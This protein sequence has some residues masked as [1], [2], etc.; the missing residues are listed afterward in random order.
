M[1]SKIILIIVTLIEEKEKNSISA[2]SFLMNKKWL[3][4]NGKTSETY[5]WAKR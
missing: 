5:I 2:N 4:N 3:Q 1:S